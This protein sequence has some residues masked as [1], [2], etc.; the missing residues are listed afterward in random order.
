MFERQPHAAF[1]HHE[2]SGNLVFF[3][4]YLK[5]DR[6]YEKL[7]TIELDDRTLGFMLSMRYILT[8]KYEIRNVLQIQTL[9]FD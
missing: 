5:D 9:G 8:I 7:Y 3:I 2:K 4:R 6:S 1:R